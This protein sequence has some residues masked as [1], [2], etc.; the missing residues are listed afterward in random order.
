MPIQA[1]NV[2][3]T[4]DQLNPRMWFGDE[5]STDGAAFQVG[6]IIVNIAP[7]VGRPTFWT[8]T[9]ATTPTFEAGPIV[10]QN[11]VTPQAITAAGTISGF[12]GL[13]TVSGFAGNVTVAP[14]LA[15]ASGFR[16]SIIALSTHSVTLVAPTGSAILGLNGAITNATVAA[17]F[18][19][20]GTNWYRLS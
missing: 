2:P 17:T 19:D 10:G 1:F 5:V 20:S 7:A 14:A 11:S 13:V 8:C 9:N 18:L 12:P 4:A 6:D 15:L 16:M 3:F